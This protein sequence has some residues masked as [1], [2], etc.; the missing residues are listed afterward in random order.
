M[1]WI[2]NSSDTVSSNC[3]GLSLLVFLYF[4]YP[5]RN[6]FFLYKRSPA[7]S[8]SPKIK[9]T[10]CPKLGWWDSFLS[11]IMRTGVARGF[12]PRLWHWP[13]KRDE[14]SGVLI[15]AGEMR[16]SYWTCRLM[17]CAREAIDSTRAGASDFAATILFGLG[18]EN[19]F[20]DHVSTLPVES[21]RGYLWI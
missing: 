12:V 9:M 17:T 11:D 10:R 3:G 21:K 16:R 7:M 13:L 14:H 6:R 5:V 1:I 4:Q 2:S 19:M 20:T 8:W 15:G 18:C